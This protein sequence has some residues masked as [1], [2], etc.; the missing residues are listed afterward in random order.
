MF[1]LSSNKYQPFQISPFT[2]LSFFNFLAYTIT[3][4]FQV[5]VPCCYGNELTLA[6]QKISMSLFHSDWLTTSGLYKKTVKI[7]LENSKKPIVIKAFEYIVINL[8]TFLSICNFAYSI[9]IVTCLD[10]IKCLVT[11]QIYRQFEYFH[12]QQ[13]LEC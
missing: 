7:F 6:S 4:L 2:D 12:Y 10:V 11:Y 13:S 8:K 9:T 1:T 5:L 3:M